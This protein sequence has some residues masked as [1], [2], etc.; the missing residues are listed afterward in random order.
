MPPLSMSA[1]P[2]PFDYIQASRRS[3]WTAWTATLTFFAGFY[4]LLTP[5]PRY[6]SSIGLPDWQIGLVLGAFGVASLL[7][8]PVAGMATDRWG[9]RPVMLAGTVLLLAGA[10]AV[11]ATANVVALF[12][13][14][15]LQ[16]TGY[17]A[18]TTAGTGLVVMLTAP[19]ERGRRLAI[20]GAAANVAITLTPAVGSALLANQPITAGFMMSAGLALAA[21]CLAWQLPTGRSGAPGSMA[22]RLWFPRRLWPAMAAAGLMG[23]GFAAFFQF[24]PLLAERRGT[25]DV[26]WLYTTYGIGIIMS[27]FGGGGLVDR[28]GTARMLALTA[29][30]MATGLAVFAV[31]ATPAWMLAATLLLA[32]SG[33]FHPALIAHHA[34]LLPDAPGR[35]SAAFYV[36][37][38]VGI[39]L[40]SWVLGATLAAA[41]LPGLYFTACLAVL[42]VLALVPGIA[43]QSNTT[44]TPTTPRN[45]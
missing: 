2:T 28:W 21:G 9:A 23:V 14:R 31:A 7:G 29:V 42:C 5:L 40:G 35:A 10:L 11:G 41:G 39:G 19:G 38:D 36:G 32:A 22:S 45:A 13:L 1:S 30:L 6:L 16:A 44:T 15:L 24:V 4:A 27:R 37:F 25:I 34:A 12:V 43:R 8:R 20:F 26:G 33:L 18:F 17:V 3:Y